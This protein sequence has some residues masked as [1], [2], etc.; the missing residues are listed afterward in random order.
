MTSMQ[1]G[2]YNPRTLG[3]RE[4]QVLAWLET[5]R[6]AVIQVGDV[7]VAVGIS[8]EHART[9]AARLERKGWLQ[10]LTRGRYA[11]LLGDTGGWAAPDPWAALDG[12]VRSHYV[13]FASAAHELGLT[14]DRPGDVQVATVFGAALPPRMANASVRLVRLRRFTLAGAAKRRLHG[15][16]IWMAGPERCIIDS[17][18]H[19]ALAGGAL[20]L[21]RMVARAPESLDWHGLVEMSEALPRGTP[22]L[23]RLGALLEILDI[24]ISPALRRAAV[25]TTRRPIPL[26]DAAPLQRGSAVL[27]R[28]RVSLNVSPEAIREEVRR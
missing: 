7:A 17:A 24:Q 15:H 5:E 26:D 23:R 9:V 27:G 8:R 18:T 3:S 14:P 1:D 21:A 16:E 20:G 25:A 12:W 28:W 4:A 19:L 13:S 22:A 6:P 2:L 11:P 10:R